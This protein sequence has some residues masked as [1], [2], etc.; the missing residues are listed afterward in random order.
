MTIGI[1][2]SD[3]AQAAKHTL[4][5]VFSP[6]S[7]E[8][9]YQIQ[10]DTLTDRQIALN[11]HDVVI[12]EVFEDELGH[13][14]PDEIRIESCTGLRQ[15]Y[16]ISPGQFNRRDSSRWCWSEKIRQLNCAQDPAFPVKR[17]SCVSRTNTP[18]NPR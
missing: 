5:Y 11:D 17:S 1:S 4:L 9:L 7:H 8:R 12:A 14:G 13:V 2:H 6:S 18:M 10:M 3:P 15:E 16:H